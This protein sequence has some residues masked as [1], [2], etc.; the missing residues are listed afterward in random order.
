MH[1]VI[2]VIILAISAAILVSGTIV[3]G[4]NP[5]V[6]DKTDSRYETVEMRRRLAIALIVIGSATAIGT[7][8]YFAT[9]KLHVAERKPLRE[10]LSKRVIAEIGGN[11]KPVED[12]S[13]RVVFNDETNDDVKDNIFVDTDLKDSQFF[14]LNKPAG[15]V[16]STNP[17]ASLRVNATQPRYSVFARA[18][19]DVEEETEEEYRDVEDDD[20]EENGG[21]I[22][23]GSDFEEIP[24]DVNAN[25]PEPKSKKTWREA[26]KKYTW[27]YM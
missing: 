16:I 18:P 20:A 12:K 15:E 1:W 5:V 14:A 6:S 10:E 21:E 23:Y 25:Q 9:N 11:I 8:V 7:S 17:T 27:G 4:T 13:R 22:D 19:E 24:S 26:L 2:F 3:L